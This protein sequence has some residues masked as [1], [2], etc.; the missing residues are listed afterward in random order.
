MLSGH[1]APVEVVL[2]NTCWNAVYM[3]DHLKAMHAA[4]KPQKCDL[5]YNASYL[6]RGKYVACFGKSSR[7]MLSIKSAWG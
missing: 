7:H 4:Q 1:C 3:L 6:T 5:C 2:G